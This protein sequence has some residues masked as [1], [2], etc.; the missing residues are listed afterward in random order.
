MKTAMILLAS[1]VAASAVGCAAPPKVMTS[2]SYLADKQSAKSLIQD[3]GIT[4]NDNE[5]LFNYYV[6]VCDLG[7]AVEEK[8]KDTLILENVTPRSLY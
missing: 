7:E 3:T 4:V 5:K 8:C 6:R 2:H 1:L